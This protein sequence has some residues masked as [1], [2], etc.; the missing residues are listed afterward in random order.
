MSSPRKAV[1]STRIEWDFR[2]SS[3]GGAVD[4]SCSWKGKP[5]SFLSCMPLSFMMDQYGLLPRVL[6]ENGLR[7]TGDLS[8]IRRE[9]WCLE[10]EVCLAEAIISSHTQMGGAVCGHCTILIFACATRPGY[11]RASLRGS[12]F[13]FSGLNDVYSKRM[14]LL[15]K[16]V[17][18]HS[19]KHGRVLVL[20]GCAFR[21]ACREREIRGSMYDRARRNEHCVCRLTMHPLPT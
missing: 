17:S 12:W 13:C 18:M 20:V 15:L 11:R 4:R 8:A 2:R 1:I 7:L 6:E 10:S 9:E 21:C 3:E 19:A 5:V 14:S 16:L